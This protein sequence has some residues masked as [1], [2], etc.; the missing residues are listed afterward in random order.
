MSP[1]IETLDSSELGVWVGPINVSV[2]TCADDVL[3]MSDSQNKLQVLLDIASKCGKMY[4]IE[5][6]ATKTKI[7]SLVLILTIR[8]IRI[9]SLG[10]WTVLR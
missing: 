5:N 3:V 9:S 10:Q 7:P 2:S 1:T 6:E 8:F 4:K